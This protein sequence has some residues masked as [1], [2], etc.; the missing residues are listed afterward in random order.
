MIKRVKDNLNDQTDQ[1]KSIQDAK[2]SM[3]LSSVLDEE[4]EAQFFATASKQEKDQY[5][6]LE[7]ELKEC[8]KVAKEEF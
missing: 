8:K 7:K 4:E 5:I 2:K 1:L 6:K 3:K